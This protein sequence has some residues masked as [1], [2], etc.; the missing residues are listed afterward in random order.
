MSTCE[1]EVE[2]ARYVLLHV[3]RGHE[4]GRALANALGLTAEDVDELLSLKTGDL[5]RVAEQAAKAKAINVHL[6]R[7][8]IR[9]ALSPF[10]ADE[11]V[12]QHMLIGRLI[13]ADAPLV[14]MRSLMGVSERQFARLR[15][16]YGYPST[17]PGHPRPTTEQ[18]DIVWHAWIDILTQCDIKL[19]E[20]GPLEYLAVKDLTGQSMRV[21]WTL[22]Q[23]WIT[24]GGAPEPDPQGL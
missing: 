1:R 8:V 11:N 22:S 14:M 4:E 5:D 20:A 24:K 19:A 17:S 6:D 18:H 10:R 13:K 9:E 12:S 21:I 3:L 7:D 2:F 23:A 16:A 15:R